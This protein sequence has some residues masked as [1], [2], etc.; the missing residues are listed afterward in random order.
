MKWGMPQ[1]KTPQIHEFCFG[2]Y[3]KCNNDHPKIINNHKN[4]Q[5]S[6]AIIKHRQTSRKSSCFFDF[7]HTQPFPLPGRS[8]SESLA[9]GRVKNTE[10]GDKFGDGLGLDDTLSLVCV[11]VIVCSFLLIESC[12][13]VV[14][15]WCG[16]NVLLFCLLFFGH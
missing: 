5:K 3:Q 11:C 1:E 8:L 9:P 10:V 7:S 4:H 13:C 15:V 6:T 12:F 14:Y 16:E 2:K